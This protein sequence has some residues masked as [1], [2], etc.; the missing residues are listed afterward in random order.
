[1]KRSGM[2]LLAAMAM[3]QA[4]PAFSQ[5]NAACVKAN[6]D[7]TRLRLGHDRAGRPNAIDLPRALAVGQNSATACQGDDSFLLA[8]A[9][10]RIDA[11][12]DVKHTPLQ[13]RT[14]LF[15]AALSDLETIRQ[16]VAAGRSD[17]YEIFNTL[18]LIYYDLQQ[19]DRSVAVLR[20][21][22][23][24][25]GRMSPDSRQKTYFTLGMAQM[26]LGLSG[27]AAAAFGEAQRN[28]HPTAGQWQRQ[29]LSRQQQA[30]KRY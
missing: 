8:Y 3:L 6:D 17:R 22:A 2:L 13:S 25:S 29:M 14:P 24:F 27:E 9:L 7:V 26:R 12:K 5:R 16:R 28:G 23:R 19:Y 30:V 4:A 11:A 1:M 15:N 10:A 20:Q 18:G 21:A